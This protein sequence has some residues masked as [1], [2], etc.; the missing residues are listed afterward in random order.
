MHNLFLKII[1]CIVFAGELSGY[2]HVQH[3]YLSVVGRKR[4][5]QQK[6]ILKLAAQKI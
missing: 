1:V 5:I 4:M 6:S 3:K 2:I